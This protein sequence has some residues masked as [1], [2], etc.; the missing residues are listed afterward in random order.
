M[1][2]NTPP[3]P[4]GKKE[5]RC[6]IDLGSTYAR[7]LT[8]GGFFPPGGA[9]VEEVS[10]ERAHIGWGAVLLERGEIGRA[11]SVRAADVLLA[12][13]DRARRAGCAYPAVLATNV[14]RAAPDRGEVVA[15]L[16]RRTGARPR[17]LSGR[18]E[19]ALGFSGATSILDRGESAVL[20]DPGGTSTEIAWGDAG[21]ADGTLSIQWGTQSVARI[22]GRG[23]GPV[24]R[25]ALRMAASRLTEDLGPALAAVPSPPADSSLPGGRPAPTILMTGGTAVALAAVARSMR[26][27]AP[28]RVDHAMRERVDLALVARRVAAAPG[29]GARRF[30]VEAERMRLL[31]PGLVLVLA[32]ARGLGSTSP[33]VTARDLRWGAVLTGEPLPEDYLADE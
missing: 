33:T 13:V 18:G 26:R 29:Y 24:S 6:C 23:R 17:V 3:R 19:A 8:V 2:V 25:G 20:A 22:L 31:L 4:K 30:P 16:E 21:R 27:D 32:I 14:L 10:E 12:L 9:R 15:L 11:A 5:V 28:L 7:L 1:I